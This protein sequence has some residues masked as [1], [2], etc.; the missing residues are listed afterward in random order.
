MRTLIDFSVTDGGASLQHITG[1]VNRIL[2]RK[3]G[4]PLRDGDILS[5]GEH[6]ILNPLNFSNH[7]QNVWPRLT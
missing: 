7:Q 1:T 6:L 4:V 5:S 3:W 2:L